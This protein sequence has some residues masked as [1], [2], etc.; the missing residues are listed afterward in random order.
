MFAVGSS[1]RDVDFLFPFSSWNYQGDVCVPAP[2]GRV[3]WILHVRDADYGWKEHTHRANIA[4]AVNRLDN[5][6]DDEL[7]KM[8]LQLEVEI[9]RAL[10]RN[11]TSRIHDSEL[12]L[13]IHALLATNRNPRNFHG[14]NLVADLLYRAKI[15]KNGGVY[16]FVV[17]ALCNAKAVKFEHLQKLSQIVP[18]T[19]H[20]YN[21][22]EDVDSREAQMKA[23][24]LKA[25]ACASD[26]SPADFSKFKP[27][28]ERAENCLHKKYDD[29]D[30]TFGNVFTT[31]LAVQALTATGKRYDWWNKQKTLAYLL[32][33]AYK[34]VNMVK[35]YY[36]EMALNAQEVRF[37]RDLYNGPDGAGPEPQEPTYYVKYTVKNGPRPEKYFTISMLVPER[38]NFYEVMKLASAESSRF[39][40]SAYLNKDGR[41]MVYALGGTPNDAEENLFWRLCR[42]YYA[43]GQ[44]KHG[45]FDESP[46]NLIPKP[47]ENLT[48]WYRNTDCPKVSHA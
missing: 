43:N 38:T 45:Q 33:E 21:H 4:V 6:T 47:D 37:I 13:F 5:F 46:E 14:T 35:A 39:E 8:A 25:F 30:G 18:S 41:P 17:L 24:A 48:F 15:S 44:S 36:I 40:F 20:G 7:G 10:F 2:K 29:E 12:A 11:K 23:I 19:H 42:H 1:Q 32:E 3:P 9:T 34:D 22:P 27:E 28:M 31:A 16:P 26:L